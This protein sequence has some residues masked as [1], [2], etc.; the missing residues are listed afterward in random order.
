M[1]AYDLPHLTNSDAVKESLSSKIDVKKSSRNVQ[2]EKGNGCRHVGWLI[3]HE[4]TYDVS[5]LSSRNEVY[6]REQE[7]FSSNQYDVYFIF[8]FVI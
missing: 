3:L 4:D 2:L 6:K 5:E 7:P 8:I 1:T